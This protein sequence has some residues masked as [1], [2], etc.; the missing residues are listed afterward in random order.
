[1]RKVVTYLVV[2]VL[3]LA[4]V[5]YF[6]VYRDGADGGT[7][8]AGRIPLDENRNTILS[9]VDGRLA[10]L[11]H[12]RFVLYDR[13]GRERVSRAVSFELPAL[14]IAGS[15]VI[16]Y[17]RDRGT[18]LVADHDGVQAEL[19]IPVLSAAGNTRGQYVL[20]TGG[21]GYRGVA[22]L[23][24]SR[25]R[26]EYKWYSADRY[27][28]AVSLS[29][30]GRRMAVAAAGL[31]GETVS[32]RITF[33][34]PGRLEPLGSADIE[35]E[36]PLDAFSPDNNHVSILTESGVHFFTDDG[37]RL[38]HFS[39]GAYRLLSH[40]ATDQALFLHIGRNESGQNSRLICLSYTG[41]ELGSVQF[42][43]GPD[44]ISAAGRWCAV[45]ET[46]VLTRYR[47]EGAALTAESLGRSHARSLLISTSGDILL[48]YSDHARW[49]N[50][51]EEV[52]E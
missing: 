30:S 2:A 5:Y 6:T 49:Y 11:S 38:G 45:L 33:L 7:A 3:L 32:A 37:V 19:N 40:H 23:Y 16:A 28:F 18:A 14:T 27:I 41:A 10:I 34:E 42:S 29:P 4:I 35:G 50:V 51:E 24:D 44:S 26:L 13:L 39:F 48:L 15:K 52:I 25:N 17:D 8:E 20:V 22:Q 36:L 31:Q 1:M 47:L 46:D 12:D 9:L 21:S 43:E